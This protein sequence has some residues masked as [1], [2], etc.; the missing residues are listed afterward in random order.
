MDLEKILL[1]K[2]YKTMNVIRYFEEQAIYFFKN[3]FIPGWLHCYIGQ[4]AV[5]VG[6]C[7]ALNSDD[8]IT[9]THRGHGHCIAKGADLKKMAAELFGKETGYCKGKGGSMHIFDSSI[10]I[11]GANGIVGGGIPIATGSGISSKYLK[12]KR[13]CISFFSDGAS[14]QGSF[15]ESL[16]LASVLKLPV[17]YL[18]ENNQYALTT[19]QRKHQNIENI[20]DRAKAY[21]IQGIICDGNDI[22]DVYKKVSEA[23]D[24]IRNNS[25]PIFIEA[26][27]YR[28]RGHWEGDPQQYRSV[29]EINKWIKKDPIEKFKSYLLGKKVFNEVSL[30]KIKEDSRWEV[31]EAFK[32]AKESPLPRIESALESVFC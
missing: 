31:D 10:G 7:L 2:M 26:K 24:S 8:Y 28:V 23:V 18:C 22:I 20:A 13:V 25:N 3:G 27:T 12:N 11:L 17:I 6:A 29:E 5:A 4:E 32:F 14:N 21:G 30:E 15:H 16:N 19:Y 9:S 1:E